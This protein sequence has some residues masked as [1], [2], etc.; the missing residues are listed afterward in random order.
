MKKIL[1]TFFIIGTMTQTAIAQ[2]G[3]ISKSIHLA[4][5]RG[6]IFKAIDSVVSPVKSQKQLFDD[7]FYNPETVSV[8]KYNGLDTKS[9]DEAINV[10]IPLNDSITHIELLSVQSSF[11][12]Y[13]V[14]TSEGNRIQSNKTAKHYRGAVKNIPNSIV[15]ISFFQDEIMGLI[16]TNE[17]NFNISFDK[18]VGNHIF[19]NN[20]NLK[21]KPIFNCGI[22]SDIDSTIYDSNVILSSSKS[23]TTI[24]PKCVHLY[25]ETEQDI[26]QNK[27][28]VASVENYVSGLF[29]QVA[30]LYQ[31]EDIYVDISEIF[32][33]TTTDPYTSSTTGGLLN[34][35]QT[36][37]VSFNG[38]LGHLL[39]FRNI[40]GGGWLQVLMDCVIRTYLKDWQFL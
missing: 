33:W 17:G 35:F 2:E 22:P 20:K 34:Q 37:R 1:V 24:I 29:N 28:N 40:G 19:Y 23:V 26:F 27:G 25:L 16:S 38:D 18:N 13:E 4:K 31:N 36:N 3:R 30:T 21:T 32:V 39:T 7:N 9:F 8:F 6:V 11:Y 14:V 15:A 5:E 12:D 10:A